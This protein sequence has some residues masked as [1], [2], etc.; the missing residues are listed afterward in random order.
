MQSCKSM[1]SVI[2]VNRVQSKSRRSSLR[3]CDA[4][5]IETKNRNNSKPISFKMK[6]EFKNNGIDSSVRDWVI[7]TFRCYT[8]VVVK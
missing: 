1:F 4:A 7:N 6:I 3:E 5:R 8:V 2:T